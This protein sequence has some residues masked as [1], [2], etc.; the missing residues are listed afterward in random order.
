VRKKHPVQVNVSAQEEGATKKI[1]LGYLKKKKGKN[2]ENNS[3][4]ERSGKWGQ[5]L[6]QVRRGT[7]K[8]G[9]IY[10]AASENR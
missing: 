5:N 2:D 8:K 4:C 1:T 3:N 6:V 10:I 7:K 9:K